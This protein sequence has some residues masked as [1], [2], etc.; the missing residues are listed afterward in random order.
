MFPINLC[1]KNYNKKDRSPCL[2]ERFDGLIFLPHGT[3]HVHL[4]SRK[5]QAYFIYNLYLLQLYL[6]NII[7]NIL[8][9]KRGYRREELNPHCKLYPRYKYGIISYII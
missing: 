6:N 8:L 7:Y 4:M 9:L 2:L 3:N 1:F 5:S